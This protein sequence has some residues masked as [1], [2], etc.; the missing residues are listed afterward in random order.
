LKISSV[1]DVVGLQGLRSVLLGWEEGSLEG[2]DS[3]LEEADI[4]KIV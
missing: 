3:G 1:A 2:G 4:E